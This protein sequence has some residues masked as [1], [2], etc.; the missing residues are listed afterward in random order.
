MTNNVNYGSRVNRECR[1]GFCDLV[2]LGKIDNVSRV[3]KFG[4]NG[5]VDIGTED[6]ISIGGTLAEF[7]AAATITITPAHAD[8]TH[9]TGDGMRTMMVYG[10]DANYDLQEE[11]F[12]LT[13]VTPVVS[14]TTWIFVYRMSGVTFGTNG[15]NTGNIVIK[16]TAGSNHI[17]IDATEGQ[18]LSAAFMVP[19]NTYAL[20]KRYWVDIDDA[21]AT[22][23]VIFRVK[24]KIFGG[25][26]VTKRKHILQ[27]G[28]SRDWPYP[29]G[30]PRYEPKSIV[31]LCL[32]TDVN[33][34][35][36]SGGFDLT[37][38]PNE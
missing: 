22:S 29:N 1:I 4:I 17:Q 26:Y 3:N 16:P 19:R 32:T 34:T 33:N 18:T 24:N 35:V 21:P 31:K 27:D 7:A 12:S 37:L 25:G 23:G 9:T 5:D 30:S 20:M 2:S 14:T 38:Y 15:T 36:V 28:V 10:L 8:E 6:I 11:L 13:G